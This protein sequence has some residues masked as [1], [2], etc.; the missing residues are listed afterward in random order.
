MNNNPTWE[1]IKGMW[2]PKPVIKPRV[3]PEFHHMGG[4]SRATEAWRYTAFATEHW[5]SPHGQLREWLRQ[6]LRL[7][8]PM[9]APVLLVVPL[10][11][12]IL[13]S[14][15]KWVVLLTSLT[16]KLVVLVILFLV[17]VVV[18]LFNYIVLSL[19]FGRRR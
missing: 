3:D 18:A 5:L 12:F 10:V 4:L 7:C 6:V 14:L 9:A 19:L 15:V 13:T 16:W 2:Q 17:G 1:R 11:T 8:I